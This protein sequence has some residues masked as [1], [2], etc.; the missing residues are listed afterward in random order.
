[1]NGQ[2]ASK[3]IRFAPAVAGGLALLTLIWWSLQH[4]PQPMSL[5]VPGT[6][7]PPG[8]SG[9][10][11]TNPVL[12]GKLIV[13]TGTP[14][15]NL[16]G[17]WLGFRGARHDADVQQPVPL[18]HSWGAGGPPVLWSLDVGEGY[19]GPAVWNGRVYLMD[20]DR[21]KHENA[22]RCLSLADGHEIWRYAYPVTIKRNHGISRTVPAVTPKY[23]VGIGPKCTVVCVDAVTGQLRWGMNLVRQFGTT[24]PPWYTGQCP[25]IDGNAV[26]LAPGGRKVLMMAVDLASGKILWQTPNT[27]AWQMTHS[28]IMPM[29]YG[30]VRQYVYCASRGVVGVS[31]KDG[32]VLWQTTDWKISI[33]TVPSPLV[34][35]GGRLF[36]SGGYDAGSLMLQLE[37]HDGQFT[38]KPLFRL[39][40]DTFGATQQTPIFYEGYIYGTRPDGRFVCLDLNG[41]VV[42]TSGPGTNFGLG[43]FLLAGGLFYVMNDSG[44]LTLVKATPARYTPLAHAQVL[45]GQESWAPLALAGN[46]LLARDLTRMVCLDVGVSQ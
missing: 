5:R 13:G 6:D 27:N 31:A 45:K 16:A 37:A 10:A 44:S 22:L 9:T 46:R 23:V 14:A 39:D 34:L 7:I 3:W 12:A 1:M 17:T 30:G 32:K 15:T 36:F 35:P 41:K 2:M 18:A 33:A 20:Y 42:W 19:A 26:I 21:A 11:L 25:L 24:V 38:P 40:A 4:T 28:S 43:P 8:S 29:D